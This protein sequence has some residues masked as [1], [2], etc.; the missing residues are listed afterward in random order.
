LSSLNNAIFRL[1]PNVEWTLQGDTLDG[2]TFNDPSIEKPTQAQL[3]SIFAQIEAEKVEA[4]TKKQA[5]KAKLIALGL[6]SEDLESL[7]LG[8]SHSV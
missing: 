4:E 6:T 1:Y 3:N 5:A 8:H 2:L 7:G